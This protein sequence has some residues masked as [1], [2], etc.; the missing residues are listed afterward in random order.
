MGRLAEAV[1]AHLGTGPAARLAQL[2]IGV[3]GCGGLGSNCAMFLARSGLC[4]FVLV[5]HDVV[6]V[7]NLNRQHFFP[8]QV[9]Q[10]KVEALSEALQGLDP[11]MDIQKV[12]QRLR[13]ETA[14]MVFQGCDALVECL[15]APEAKA[16][17]LTACASRVR[18]YVGA[19]GIA[20]HGRAHN[21]AVR[22]LGA[23]CCVVGDAVS[24]VG[25]KTPVLAPGVGAAA[26]LQ[27]D[28]VL[29]YFLRQGR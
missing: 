9:G 15:D 17:L 22:W 18:L 23:G 26:A 5:D 25:G 11:G 12:A 27:A 16:W 2:R 28:V 3:A 21:L 6:E 10:L 29:D 19:S 7:S 4:R 13:P 24:E 1:A 14:P 20:G 8:Q